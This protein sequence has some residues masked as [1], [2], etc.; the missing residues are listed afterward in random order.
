MYNETGQ[1]IME[2]PLNVSDGKILDRINLS[3]LKPGMYFLRI[4]G[5]EQ[6]VVTKLIKTAE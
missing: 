5:N 3:G 1:T 6:S 2:M 4:W